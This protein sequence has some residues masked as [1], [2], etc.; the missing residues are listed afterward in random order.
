MGQRMNQ[1]LKAVTPA[2]A[3]G[4][5]HVDIM[6]R[7]YERGSLDNDQLG[8]ALFIHA[9]GATPTP[10]RIVFNAATAD[11]LAE[12]GAGGYI[13][14]VAHPALVDGGGYKPLPEGGEVQLFLNERA[15]VWLHE[16]L[17]QNIEII[18]IARQAA[19]AAAKANQPKNWRDRL[20]KVLTKGNV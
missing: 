4:A 14:I 13:C 9:D 6:G 17:E 20:A 16:Q 11:Q 3:D 12:H 10:V 1:V 15:K 5:D 7:V 8:K 2:A 18:K 19:A